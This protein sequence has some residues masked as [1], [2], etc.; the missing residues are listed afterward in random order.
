MTQLLFAIAVCMAQAVAQGNPQPFLD[1]YLELVDIGS[2]KQLFLDDHVILEMVGARREFHRPWKLPQNPLLRPKN[3]EENAVVAPFAVFYDPRIERFRLWYMCERTDETTSVLYAESED[4]IRWER[5]A[6]T[7]DGRP[8]GKFS[9]FNKV[10]FR[11]P[12]RAGELGR[13]VRDPG[14]IV[15][16]PWEQDPRRRY[17]MIQRRGLPLAFSPDGYTWTAEPEMVPSYRGT[18]DEN[19]F[20]YDPKGRRWLA[21]L[22]QNPPYVGWTHLRRIIIEES[23]DMVTWSPTTGVL[24]PDRDDGFG[25]SF[26]R[27]QAYAYEGIYVALPASFISAE[28]HN[29]GWR[30]Q[31][32]TELAYS[33]DGLS[34]SRLPL[35]PFIGFGAERTWDRHKAGPALMVTHGDKIFFHYLGSTAQHGSS[36]DDW[37][38]AMGAAILRRDG[39]VSLEAEAPEQEPAVVLTKVLRF[40]G[41]R[42]YLNADAQGGEI[43]VDL[44]I[45]GYPGDINA[46]DMDQPWKHRRR[47]VDPITSDSTR[48]VVQW[49]GLADVSKVQGVPI[50]LRFII[51]GRAKL[52]AFQFGDRD[53]R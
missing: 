51:T 44:L 42:L 1:D 32:Q 40:Q 10:W 29:P 18:K 26:V 31:I 41:D 2:T 21:F 45:G 27:C 5:R 25:T 52:Y 50:R 3:P 53:A 19:N 46:S 48:H 30:D 37:E 39:F 43:R 6:S 28:H 36:S 12:E 13:R 49:E 20:M 33:R 16:H 24:Q 23:Q 14:A 17:K 9:P 34:W 8:A 15:Y 11:H 7:A 38:T 4:G 35:R 47:S 22:R